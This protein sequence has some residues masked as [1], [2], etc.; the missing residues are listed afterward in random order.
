M[1][2]ERHL[3][4][5]KTTSQPVYNAE[6]KRM[7]VKSFQVT[8]NKHLK[9]FFITYPANMKDFVTCDRETAVSLEEVE[10]NFWKKVKEFQESKRI[11]DKM[12]GFKF[13]LQ[14]AI[15]KNG[16]VQ[17]V[18]HEITNDNDNATGLLLTWEIARRVTIGEKVTHYSQN[19]QQIHDWQ[20]EYKYMQWTPER[21][22]FFKTMQASLEKM[23]MRV[24]AFIGEEK[25]KLAAFIDTNKGVM[26]LPESPKVK[27]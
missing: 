25:E 27:K 7:Q 23:V 21:E 2:N 24:D 3:I 10:K 19:G 1:E 4:K 6:E 18:R 15:I 8:F 5:I 17:E 9:S 26:L 16:I 14:C 13:A 22:L 20:D 11:E 12:I